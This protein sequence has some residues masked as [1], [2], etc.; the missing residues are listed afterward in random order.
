MMRCY[1]RVADGQVVGNPVV[2]E[3]M[4]QA[5]PGID[6]NNLPEGW[7]PFDRYAPPDD[8]LTSLTQVPVCTYMLSSDGVTWQDVWTAREMTD[9]ERS[10]AYAEKLA[11][12]S[13]FPNLTL[14]AATLVWEPNTPMPTDGKTYRWKWTTGEWVIVTT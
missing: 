13:K 4:L 10:A 3:N 7:A 9:E 6:L 1:I 5:F 14:S 11:A 2:A 12:G 8:L